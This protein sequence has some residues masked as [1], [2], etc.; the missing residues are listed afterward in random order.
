[1][2][3]VPIQ[4]VVNLRYDLINVRTFGTLLL[5]ALSVY[6]VLDGYKVLRKR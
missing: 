4:L 6:E 3:L 1:M 2:K 5:V